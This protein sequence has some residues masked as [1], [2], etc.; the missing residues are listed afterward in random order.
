MQTLPF[1]PLTTAILVGAMF[2]T[3]AVAAATYGELASSENIV[4]E[5]NSFEN[6]DYGVGAENGYSAT[7][8]SKTDLIFKVKKAGAYVDAKKTGSIFFDGRPKTSN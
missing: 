8:N 6:V 3:F 5:Q 7:V 2:P 1:K 4:T